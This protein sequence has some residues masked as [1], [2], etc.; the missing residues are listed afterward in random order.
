MV[1]LTIAIYSYAQKRAGQEP[2]HLSKYRHHAT[3]SGASGRIL[4]SQ[5]AAARHLYHTLFAA[6]TIPAGTLF[7]PYDRPGVF[8]ID[9]FFDV[10]ALVA[11]RDPDFPDIDRVL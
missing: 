9:R 4:I 5:Q 2:G 1:L 10:S 7:C 11:V 3:M 6:A 8:A